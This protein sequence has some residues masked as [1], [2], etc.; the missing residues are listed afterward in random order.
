MI[1]NFSWVIPCRLAGFGVLSA[2]TATDLQDLREQGIGALVSLTEASVPDDLVLESGLRY[3][4]LPV[5]DMQAP[6][7]GEIHQFVA[8]V[9][10]A[11]NEGM[12]T[13]VH[14][15]AGLGRTG[16]MLACYLVHEGNPPDSALAQLRVDRPGSVETLSQE[17][18]VYEFA[19][20]LSASGV[21]PDRRGEV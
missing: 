13:A 19:R 14:C 7:L 5:P 18:T 10:E 12:A 20:S 6:S 16:T 4:H 21:S 9:D 17:R 1:S 15:L 3:R 8:F 11:R 2:P